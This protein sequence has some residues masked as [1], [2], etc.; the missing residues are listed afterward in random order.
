MKQYPKTTIFL[1]VLTFLAFCMVAYAQ[2]A[3]AKDVEITFQWDADNSG[4]WEE[5]RLFERA[6]QG[7]YDYATP[8]ST[9][10]QTYAND[11][12]QP[13]QMTITTDFM[14]GQVTTKFWVIRAAAGELESADSDEVSFTVNLLPLEQFDFTAVYN[15]VTKTIDMAWQITDPR[16]TRWEIYTSDTAGGPY[17]P[18]TTVNNVEGAETSYS[19]E[20]ESLFPAGERTTKYFTMVAFAPYD[21]FS[22]NSP[23]I[24]ITINKRPPSGVVNFKII[25][26][27]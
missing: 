26:T 22:V 20:E 6:E 4:N 3:V 7:T 9:L 21:I 10:P 8:K 5:L 24:S 15:E 1:I 17:Q 13:T 12:S 23:E 19:V 25:L 18:L 2:R 11:L 27:K 14:D 16:I